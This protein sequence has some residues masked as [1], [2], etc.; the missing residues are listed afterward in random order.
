MESRHLVGLV[1][2]SEELFPQIKVVAG[3]EEQPVDP[4]ADD[5]PGSARPA[6]DDDQ[7]S[8]QRLDL[9]DT[10]RF[11]ETARENQHVAPRKEGREPA[12]IEEAGKADLFLHASRPDELSHLGEE[13]RVGCI[14]RDLGG[15][16][17]AGLM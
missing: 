15:K 7:S 10:E 17:D 8:R 13:L 14:T 11:L 9:R 1:G 2:E 3:L 5:L 4:V 6:R 16:I 12:A